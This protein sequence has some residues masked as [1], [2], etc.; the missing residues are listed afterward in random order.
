MWRKG[1]KPPANNKAARY[2]KKTNTAQ[3]DELVRRWVAK[4]PADFSNGFGIL[5]WVLV[6]KKSTEHLQSECNGKIVFKRW[7]FSE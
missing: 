7:K 6:F 3:K 1:T 2:V 4:W 5:N